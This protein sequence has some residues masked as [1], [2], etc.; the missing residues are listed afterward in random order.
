[1]VIKSKLIC[2][3]LLLTSLMV[4]GAPCVADDFSVGTSSG[5]VVSP[6]PPPPPP[7]PPLPQGIRGTTGENACACIRG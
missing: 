2:A 5:T 3:G 6:P 1:M 4:P 7:P